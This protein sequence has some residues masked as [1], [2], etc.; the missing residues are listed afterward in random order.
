MLHALAAGDLGLGA[1]RPQAGSWVSHFH[2]PGSTVCPVFPFYNVVLLE[3][4]E[5]VQGVL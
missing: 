2:L 3:A 4:D 1:K 5:V